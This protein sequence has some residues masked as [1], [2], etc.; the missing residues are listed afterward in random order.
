MKHFK[1]TILLL[2]LLFGAMPIIVWGDW[3][4]RNNES[5][6]SQKSGTYRDESWESQKPGTY[7]DKSWR[8]KERPCSYTSVSYHKF[9]D[10]KCMSRSSGFCKYFL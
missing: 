9:I 2:V 10:S 4:S 3:E 6:E 1:K 7:S 8:T 5:W